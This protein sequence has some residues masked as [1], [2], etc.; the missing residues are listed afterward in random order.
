MVDIPEYFY[1]CP[2]GCENK[3]VKCMDCIE[4]SNFIPIKDDELKTLIKKH[5]YGGSEK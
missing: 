4:C 1:E 5:T 2:D 3:D